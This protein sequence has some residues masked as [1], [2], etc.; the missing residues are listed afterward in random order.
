VK[1]TIVEHA[2]RLYVDLLGVRTLIKS[3]DIARID[4]LQTLLHDVASLRGPFELIDG[5]TDPRITR[6]G[7]PDIFFS[8]FSTGSQ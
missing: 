7:T 6:P 8:T 1:E 2:P 3:Q 5:T 4:D